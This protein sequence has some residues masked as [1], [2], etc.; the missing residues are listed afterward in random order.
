MA[1]I[2]LHNIS[3]AFGGPNILEDITLQIEKNQRVCLLGRNGVGKSTLMRIIHGNIA[4]DSGE[5][6]KQQGVKVSCLEQQ[7]PEIKGKDVFE[8]IAEEFGTVSKSLIEYR[9]LNTRLVDALS[10]IE[11]KRLHSVRHSLDTGDGWKVQQQVEKVISLLSLDADADFEQ[12]SGGQK[13]RVLLAKAFANEPDLLLLDEPTNHLD[14]DSITWLEDLLIRLGVTLLFVTHDRMFLKKLATRIIELDRGRLVDWSCDYETFLIRK[15]AV[16]NAE[17]GEWTRFDRKLAQEE[18]WIRKGLKAR[19][20]RNE[21]RVRALKKM[22]EERAKRRERVGTV[23]MTLQDAD[24]SGRLVIKAK[25]ISFAYT[26]L[27]IIT[28]FTTTILRGDKVG[29]IGPNGS[30]KTTLINLLLGEL[31]SSAGTLDLG[32]NLEIIYFDQL[33]NLIDDKKTVQQNVLPNGE[34]VTING[35]N[36]H[37]MGY[38]KDFLFT[39]EEAKTPVSDLSGG[40]KNRLALAKLFTKKSNLLVFDEPTNDLDTDTLELLE[41]LLINYKGTVLLVSHDRTFLNNIVTSILVMEGNGVVKEY[42]G[43]YDDWI[44]QKKLNK[45]EKKVDSDNI[46]QK[47][48]KK[49][50]QKRKLSYN[51]KRELESL[52]KNIEQMEQELEQLHEQMADPEFYS[53]KGNIADAQKKAKT[54]EE[55]LAEAYKR[56]EI[57]DDLGL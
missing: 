12:L 26:D 29:I 44:D 3:V 51:E 20:T 2:S 37:I 57:L 4:S 40:E 31:T 36:K 1:L 48:I 11:I 24:K 16:L 18:V 14:I 10:D 7:V 25:N 39:P 55:N 30:G 52:P 17:D 43:G 41:E 23:S 33:R 27:P 19:R 15:Q 56:W 38:L 21:G 5:V 54:L 46:K 47:I 35:N 49:P 34:I 32:T 45:S 8:V 50:L 6:R 53:V 28:N 42:V 22:R 9:Q 13:R